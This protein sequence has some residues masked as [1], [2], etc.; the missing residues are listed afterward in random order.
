MGNYSVIS[1]GR[2]S[3][4]GRPRKKQCLFTVNNY[5]EY[6]SDSDLDIQNLENNVCQV[7]QGSLQSIRP[8]PNSVLPPKRTKYYHDQEPEEYIYTDEEQ[9]IYEDDQQQQQ[10]QQQEI[11]EYIC[12]DEEQSNYEDDP[13]QQIGAATE[14]GEIGE[15][16]C[17]DEE[18]SNYEDD[19]QEQQIGEA[20][21][22]HDN[23]MQAAR[24]A[25]DGQEQ[26]Q[27]LDGESSTEG[28]IGDISEEEQEYFFENLKSQ[29]L[30]TETQHNVSKSA[31]EAFWKVALRNF[32]KLA[33][34]K[35]KTPQFKTIRQKMHQDLL[36]S[37]DMEIAYRNKASGEITIIKDSITPRKKFPS[38]EYEKIFEIGTLQVSLPL[39]NFRF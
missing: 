25:Q 11:G 18:Q 38:N 14:N 32:P 24:G 29:W 39:F 9:S 6:T 34:R 23:D 15:Y 33:K 26:V 5:I 22:N 4:R 16:I 19:P 10:Q 20:P 2:M 1:A 37:I 35:R 21:Q 3:K 31:S 30:L 8:N 36:P 13:Q 7:K 27:N 28:E 12:T 17:T